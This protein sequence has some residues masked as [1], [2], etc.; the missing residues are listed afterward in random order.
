MSKYILD[1]DT[2]IYWLNG[3]QRIENKILKA[4]L[5]NVF[6]TI[7]TE[8]ELYYG[9]YKSKKV[10]K[11]LAVI[12][13]LRSKVKTLHSSAEV[14]PHYGSIKVMLE[15]KGMPL[16]D[17]D[18]LIA[19]ITLSTEGTLVSNNNSHFTRIPGL[20]LENWLTTM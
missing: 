18:L 7:I 17:A 20:E 16:D 8:C 2:C 1:T 4:G 12:D 3:N 15:R 9:A 6:I 13:E 10:K 19:C 5:E 14:A 11:N